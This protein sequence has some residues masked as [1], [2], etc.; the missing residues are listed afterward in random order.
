MLNFSNILNVPCETFQ[1]IAKHDAAR[2]ALNYL[3]IMTKRS[4]AT[5]EAESP[6]ATEN[7]TAGKDPA[8]IREAG[9][10]NGLAGKK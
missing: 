6:A 8:Q 5:K 7:K 2:N 1:T 9:T 3:K 4:P 10:Q